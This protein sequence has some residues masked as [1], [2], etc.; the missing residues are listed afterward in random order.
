M[1]KIINF[2]KS[3]PSDHT[4]K[5]LRIWVGLVL[6]ALLGLGYMTYEVLPSLI[7]AGIAQ[8]ITKIILIVFALLPVLWGIADLPLGKKKAVSYALSLFGLF[9]LIIG[10]LMMPVSPEVVA[11][12]AAS[13]L[14]FAELSTRESVSDPID[15][16]FYVALIGFVVLLVGWTGKFVTSR[17]LKHGE[18]I[19]KIRV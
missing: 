7:P 9:W 16:G 13:P 18:K 15:L 4:I 17:H 10:N 5:L 3:R 19:T 14:S 2:I 1:L 6:T 11:Q 12:P 8:D